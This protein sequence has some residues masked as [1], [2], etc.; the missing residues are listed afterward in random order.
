MALSHTYARCLAVGW[1]VGSTR[2]IY[3]LVQ[4]RVIYLLLHLRRT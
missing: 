3:P 1:S 4:E 2:L